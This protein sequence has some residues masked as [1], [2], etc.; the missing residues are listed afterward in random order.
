[1][2]EAGTDVETVHVAGPSAHRADDGLVGE[3]REERGG[4][5]NTVAV[6]RELRRLLADSRHELLGDLLDLV[7]GERRIGGRVMKERGMRIGTT[8]RVDLEHITYLGDGVDVLAARSDDEPRR[9]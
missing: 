3:S 6:R 4:A 7:V 1:M 2:L 5:A 8:R 9:K